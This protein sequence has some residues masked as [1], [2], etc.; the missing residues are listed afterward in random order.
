MIVM[1]RV[2]S[3]GESNVHSLEAWIRLYEEEM[4]Y[5]RQHE[6][7]RTSSASLIAVTT[8]AVLAFLA[9]EAVSLEKQPVLA[10]V[11]AMFVVAIN[12]VG[13]LLGRKHYERTRRHQAIAQA[14]RQVISD[15][16]QIGDELLTGVR[17]QADCKHESKAS[18]HRWATG[19]SVHKLWGAIHIVLCI[20]G[21]SLVG[22]IC[23]LNLM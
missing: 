23:W 8:G 14:Y 2:D 7:L 5:A 20:L 9:S 16:S 6:S 11:L 22:Y 18:F 1:T 15:N 3:E 19:V 21:V 17:H 12:L 13:W 10:G 4:T